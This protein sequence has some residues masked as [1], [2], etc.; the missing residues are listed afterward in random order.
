MTWWGPN[1]SLRRVLYRVV[2]TQAF[3]LDCSRP[4]RRSLP[5]PKIIGYIAVSLL[6]DEQG[7]NLV[8]PVL[9]FDLIYFILCS[10]ILII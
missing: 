2:L 9:T 8:Y 6:G 3:C 10:S 5:E 4:L 1:Q 7:S